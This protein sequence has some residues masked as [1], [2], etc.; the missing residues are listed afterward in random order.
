MAWTEIAQRQ[1]RRDGL[2]YASGLSDTEWGWK[3]LMP[4]RLALGGR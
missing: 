3:P 2:H 1:Y 4:P